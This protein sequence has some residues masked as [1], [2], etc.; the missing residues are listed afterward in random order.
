MSE[1]NEA[2][3][4][5]EGPWPAHEKRVRSELKHKKAGD[6]IFNNET[7]KKPNQTKPNKLINPRKQRTKQKQQGGQ[8]SK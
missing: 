3:E 6:S 2:N 4:R 5:A 7:K 8:T 1:A